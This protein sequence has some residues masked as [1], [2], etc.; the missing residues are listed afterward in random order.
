MTNK[1]K[2]NISLSCWTCFSIFEIR[3]RNKFGMT[4]NVT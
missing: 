2:H 1:N 4:A 3:F